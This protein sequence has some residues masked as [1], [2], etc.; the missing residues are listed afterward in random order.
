MPRQILLN[1]FS[2]NC[3]AHQS[4]GLWRH[5]RDRS[6]EYTSAKHWQDL[7]RT[8]ERG[9]FDGIFLAD[10]SGVYDVYR[11][12]P[13]A[14]LR[15]ATQIPANDPFSIIPSM[16]A[17]TEHLGFGVT[18]S[19]PYEPPY[20]FARR[21]STLDH[22]TDGRI[23]WNVVTG[24]LDSAA[25]GVGEIAQTSHDTR[26]DIAAEYM[27]VVY[28]LWEGSWEDGAVLYDK[29]A[30]VFADPAM[31]HKITH[32]GEYFKL[33]A[34]HLC[35]PSPQRSPVI[36]QAGSSPKGQAFAANHAECMFIG[37]TEHEPTAA[38]VS[39]LREQAVGM[40]RR[41]EDL[42]IFAMMSVVV[43]ETD[44]AA[45]AKFEDFKSYGLLEGSLAL[46][47]GW[48]G[49]DLSQF[50]LDEAPGNVRGNAIQGS[51]TSSRRP[52][53]RQLGNALTV[54][55]GANVIV[56]SPTTVADELQAW[57]EA[58]DIDGFNLAYTVLPE[59]YEEFVDMVV[60]ELQARGIY[61]TAYQ[62]GTMRRKL[63][64]EG[65]RLPS[66]HPADAF[67]PS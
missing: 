13:D 64:G 45:L 50:D 16:S 2:M 36:F 46:A 59:C 15:A 23:A 47:S 38:L 29:E 12:S 7:A 62:A 49:V 6:R 10:V 20:S 42:K 3:I 37:A 63:F 24:Y 4:M 8:L 56:G 61:K 58:T 17:V 53:V 1:A 48:R 25:R 43:D 51:G 22:L 54:G 19:I 27:E 31:I 34:I 14:A 67:R 5:P 41:A 26:Y 55:G 35:E 52:T 21:I 39:S 9:L 33:N 57:M 65:D 40:G 60:P 66:S 18:G 44:A 32:E 28:K 11:G 30:G